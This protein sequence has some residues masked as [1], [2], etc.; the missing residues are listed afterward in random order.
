MTKHL[1]HA[2]AAGAILAACGVSQTAHANDALLNKLVSKGILTKQEA[3]ELKK[4]EEAGFDKAYRARTGL[5]EWV[6]SLRIYGDVRGRVE[7]FWSEN[8]LYNDRWRMRY[9]LRAGMVATFKDNLEMGFRLTSSEPTGTGGAFGGEPTS[10]N[11]TFQNNGSK[12]FVYMDL[13]YGKW[14]PIKNDEWLVSGTIGKM[15]NPFALSTMVF[16]DD[17]TPEGIGLNVAYNLSKEHTLRFNGGFFWLDEINQ[18]DNATDD[19]V[20]VGGQTRWDAKW[21][22]RIDSSI[23]LALLTI[24]EEHSLSDAA[25]PNLAA[26]NTRV[27]GVLVED[28]TPAIVDAAVTYTFDSGP[29]Y[30]GKFPIRL[31]ATYLNNLDASEDD[32]GYEAGVTF[33]KAGKK[34]T[35][36]LAYR[37]KRLENDAWYEEVT[38][39]DFGGFLGVGGTPGYTTGTGLKGHVLKAS[40]SPYDALTLSVTYYLVEFIDEPLDDVGRRAESEM[41]R[42]Q[43]DAVWRF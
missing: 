4:E 17:Y 19:P 21:S 43:I 20:M 10:A 33:G 2:L 8:E 41:H 1:T 42:M 29:L 16:D 26:G 36:E 18:G 5:P 7:G 14:T 11:T 32:N 34:G 38:D 23:G 15:E 39:S 13:A 30:K 9:R 12:K 31:A 6:T 3:E 40:Y 37:W 24:S 35:W 25:V 28:F 27:D 22:S